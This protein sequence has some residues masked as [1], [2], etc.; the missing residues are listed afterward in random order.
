[1]YLCDMR[2]LINII[3]SLRYYVVADP[4]DN[5]I[6]LSKKLFYHIKKHAPSDND[7]KVFVFRIPEHN[8]FGFMT[9]P[10]ID[11]E[12]QLCQIQYNGKYKCIGFETL[13][14]SVGLI[15]FTY[16]LPPMKKVKLSV[17]IK[18]TVKGDM[19]YQFDKPT[20]YANTLR[21]K[22]KKN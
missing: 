8:T 16:G 3:N 7:T 18:K 9:N 22:N 10:D 19:Y 21:K 17:S 13:C 4:T 12:T 6:T 20:K 11:K 2:K 5:S 1:M 14:P 15:F